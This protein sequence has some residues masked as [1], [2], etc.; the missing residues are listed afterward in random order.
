[1]ETYEI[2][3]IRNMNKKVLRIQICTVA[4]KGGS[5]EYAEYDDEQQREK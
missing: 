2:R 5:E 1:M 3:E 4:K